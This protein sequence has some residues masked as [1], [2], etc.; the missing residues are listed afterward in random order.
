LKQFML[1]T[2]AGFLHNHL[3]HCQRKFCYSRA[4]ANFA[5]A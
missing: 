2:F 4:S 3:Q 1:T 5:N